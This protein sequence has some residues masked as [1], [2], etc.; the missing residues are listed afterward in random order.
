MVISDGSAPAP[1]SELKA[2]KYFVG[3]LCYLVNEDF[4]FDWIDFLVQTGY[5]GSYPPGTRIETGS[6]SET[7]RILAENP[8]DKDEYT[9]Y[10][11][12]K[13]AKFFCSQ[14]AFGD[15]Y[16]SD[17]EDRNYP[18][19]AGN[20]GC[21]P[22][23]ELDLD[24]SIYSGIEE[25]VEEVEPNKSL[26]WNEGHIIEF[27]EEFSCA[28]VDEDGVIRIGRLSINTGDLFDWE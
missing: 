6:P 25:L 12:Y 7:E 18:V 9:G 15:G 21:F 26:E 17:N 16:Y 3:D 20:I 5:F 4:G 13:G 8:F 24:A 19:D 14:T 2:G 28:P 1:I 22:M 10:F 23:E 11:E 27:A